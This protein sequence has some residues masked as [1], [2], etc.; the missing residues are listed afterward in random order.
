MVTWYVILRCFQL[1]T[2]IY[3]AVRMAICSRVCL[4]RHSPRCDRAIGTCS[5]VQLQD[6]SKLGEYQLKVRW[7][8]GVRGAQH[9]SSKK[10]MTT[11]KWRPANS[12]RIYLANNSDTGWNVRLANW[13]GWRKLCRWSGL[14]FE[15]V[16]RT[17]QSWLVLV[18]L[19]WQ[20]QQPA[21]AAMTKKTTL[22]AQSA[23]SQMPRIC[24][25][26][27]AFS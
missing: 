14:R 12:I 9:W 21:K 2:T 19:W 22:A 4:F 17:R 26:P 23:H 24:Q 8:G 7:F 10:Y 27:V 15:K 13:I 3:R 6:Y 11:L 16:W 25:V 18:W 20:H 1:K 5:I